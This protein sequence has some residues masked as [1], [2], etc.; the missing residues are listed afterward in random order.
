MRLLPS[1]K[2]C[3]EYQPNNLEALLVL[4]AAQTELGLERSARATGELI[5]SRFPS[6]DVERWLEKNPYQRRELVERWKGDLMSAGA[7]TS[8]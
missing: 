5:R 3:L 4:A 1:P 6:V 8:G 7:I 2:V